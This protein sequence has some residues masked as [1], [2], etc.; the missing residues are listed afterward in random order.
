MVLMNQQMVYESVGHKI[1]SDLYEGNA[2]V[3]FAYGLSGSGKTFTVFGPD[4]VDIPE[5]CRPIA[6]LLVQR[7]IRTVAAVR[8]SIYQ[9]VSV[10][11]VLVW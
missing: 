2:V 1:K 3:L 10:Y 9:H 6:S 7:Y 11:S 5:V 4:A 8:H